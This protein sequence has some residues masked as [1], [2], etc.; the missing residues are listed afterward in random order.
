[1]WC[2]LQGIIFVGMHKVK[3]VITGTEQCWTSRTKV[4]GYI[5]FIEL[6]V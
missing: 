2:V 5:E 3:S 4:I 6:R 1:M